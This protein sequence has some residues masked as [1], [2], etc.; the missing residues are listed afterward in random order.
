MGHFEYSTP[1][2]GG[3]SNKAVALAGM[4]IAPK[5]GVDAAVSILVGTKNQYHVQISPPKS[6]IP[7]GMV[8]EN[9]QTIER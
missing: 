3:L 8:V 4:T 6:E 1:Q 9:P 5:N 7:W 2:K